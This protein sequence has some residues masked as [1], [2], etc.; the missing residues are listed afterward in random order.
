MQAT[1]LG[2]SETFSFQEIE[3]KSEK[4]FYISGYISTKAID[5]FNDTITDECLN[6]MLVQIKSGSIK[7]DFEHETIHN[8]NLDINPVAR[9]IDAKLDHKG[10][11][12][13]AMVNSAH[14]RFTEIKGSIVQGFLDAFSIAFKPL[15]TATRYIQGKAIRVLNKVKLINVGITGTPVNDECRLDKVM[16]KALNE[17][18]LSDIEDEEEVEIA[19]DDMS[20][21]ELKHKYIKRTG[22]SGNYTYFYRDGS[23]SKKPKSQESNDDYDKE[24]M[25]E[26][27]EQANSASDSALEEALDGKNK[28]QIEEILK[29]QYDLLSPGEIEALAK[30]AYKEGQKAMKDADKKLT[31]QQ[32]MEENEKD[33][34]LIKK[35]DKKFEKKALDTSSPL[36]SGESQS[37]EKSED[38]RQ[39]T[40]ETK[41]VEEV[42]KAEEPKAEEPKEEVKTPSEVEAV[43]EELAEVKAQ[44]VKL[45]QQ[46][47]KPELKAIQEAMPTTK[48][49]D[50]VTPLGLIG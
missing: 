36:V 40:E 14:K 11:W 22:T 43:K 50:N 49:K 4:E 9:I 23:S 10:L 35:V 2:T 34:E 26:K 17:I 37:S 7:I 3:G 20:D 6:D 21:L 1:Y 47:A 45:Q 28:K 19:L 8:E 15:E 12:V 39:M 32:E 29:K 46:L 27:E 30:D 48:Q 44:L 33:D 18:D 13:K 5:K 38:N 42:A 24:T 25:K 16:V 31:K 41:P